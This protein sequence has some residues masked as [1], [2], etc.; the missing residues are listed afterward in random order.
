LGLLCWLIVGVI[1][2]IG[3]VVSIGIIIG[4]VIS[5]IT[6]ICIICVISIIRVICIICVISII[7]VICII[8]YRHRYIQFNILVK[9]L[10]IIQSTT[11]YTIYHSPPTR[12]PI[13]T[14]NI[15][16]QIYNT[17][18]LININWWHN[19]FNTIIILQSSIKIWI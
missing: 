4:I 5:I 19:L 6:I 17:I 8:D 13:Q 11:I 12:Y 10:L 14:P 3:V 18:L 2:C 9:I 7:C 16:P 15:T 1:V